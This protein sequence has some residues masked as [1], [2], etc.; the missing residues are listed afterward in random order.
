MQLLYSCRSQIATFQSLKYFLDDWPRFEAMLRHLTSCSQDANTDVDDWRDRIFFVE[1]LATA[2]LK[3]VL[4]IRKKLESILKV[5]ENEPLKVGTCDLAETS[6]LL[7]IGQLRGDERPDE[8][9]NDV[10]LENLLRV[11][12]H[13]Q[14]NN[15]TLAS[16]M[17]YGQ[18][19]HDE[20]MKRLQDFSDELENASDSDF[21][22]DLE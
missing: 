18:A 10:D 15:V 1:P 22:C 9:A 21:F 2:L 14:D 16:L 19:A 8:M 7:N 11:L 20:M 13:I 3:R 17:T 5:E 4:Y 12:R 6:K